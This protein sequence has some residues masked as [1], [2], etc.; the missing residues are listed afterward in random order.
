M[1]GAS[2]MQAIKN[3]NVAKRVTVIVSKDQYIKTLV[4]Q[5]IDATKD[6]KV[7]V[8]ADIVIICTNLNSYKKVI[9]GLNNYANEKVIVSDI[10]SV[11]GMAE[12]LFDKLYKYPGNF[13]PA[14]PIAGSERS[15][16]GVVIENLYAG[17]KVIITRKSVQGRDI[18]KMYEAIGMKVEYLNSQKHDQIY[19]EISHLPQL[20]AFECRQMASN[21][22]GALEVG[23]N[24]HMQKFMRL[25]ESNKDLWDEI[26]LHNMTRIMDLVSQYKQNYRKNSSQAIFV[27]KLKKYQKDLADYDQ[28]LSDSDPII[29]IESIQQVIVAYLDSINIKNVQY[30]GSGFRDFIQP[31]FA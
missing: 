13:V 2:L 12:N 19:A 25:G 5:G 8:D 16:F 20:L 28:G 22:Y 15:G 17:K 6:Y 3:N 1:M 18:A 31:I 4:S 24:T 7:I 29:N 30:S 11:K 27:G 10:G 14:H 26:F 9:T 21:F 23:H